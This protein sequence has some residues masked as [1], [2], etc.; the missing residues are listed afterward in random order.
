MTKKSSINTLGRFHASLPQQQLGG[1]VAAQSH[2]QDRVA[3]LLT[4][5]G[6]HLSC[7][8]G[9]EK[10]GHRKDDWK[11]TSYEHR[12]SDA[13][14]GI[15]N[16]ETVCTATMRDPF[17]TSEKFYVAYNATV[18]TKTK[19]MVKEIQGYI[20]HFIKHETFEKSS[21]IPILIGIYVTHNHESRKLFGKN[22]GSLHD[23]VRDIKV[24]DDLFV[25]VRG[26][27]DEV[28]NNRSDTPDFSLIAEKY[29]QFVVTAQTCIDSR[30]NFKLYKSLSDALIRPIQDV[31]KSLALFKDKNQEI[32]FEVQ[33]NPKN[34]HAEMALLF[35]FIELV[36]DNRET[37]VTNL[38]QGKTNLFY[39]GV[40]KL[41]CYPCHHLLQYIEE[42][43]EN[44]LTHRGT[45]ETA[46]DAWEIISLIMTDLYEFQGD[47]SECTK[48]V[49]KII[50]EANDILKKPTSGK[51]Q[52][53]EP[54]RRELSSEKSIPQ[55]IKS[56]E[57]IKILKDI[58]AIRTHPKMF[59]IVEQE[60]FCKGLKYEL[61]GQIEKSYFAP[62]EEAKPQPLGEVR[63]LN[64]SDDAMM[65]QVS[66]LGGNDNVMMLQDSDLSFF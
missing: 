27:I 34:L 2:P 42:K 44:I 7:L 11:K 24:L 61:L 12:V 30:G 17:A 23:Q 4:I 16:L 29:L 5:K 28:Q 62:N 49:E 31:I 46:Y 39:I 63:D 18:T 57:E 35:K 15:L 50:K 3:P 21:I 40:D 9:Q 45:H 8:R 60:E 47:K 14:A 20:N 25:E 19:S 52:D 59:S 58:K 26:Y 6:S 48:V 37:I 32:D 64:I 51:L 54:L 41:S 13:L 36:K 1:G 22:Q 38:Q 65:S 10:L 33:D 66:A 43:F 56:L 55:G 53:F